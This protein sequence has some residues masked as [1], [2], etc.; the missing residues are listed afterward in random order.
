MVKL[1]TL[2]STLYLSASRKDHCGIIGMSDSCVFT[3]TLEKKVKFWDMPL[4]VF[5]VKAKRG[6]V[7]GLGRGRLREMFRKDNVCKWETKITWVRQKLL[8]GFNRKGRAYSFCLLQWVCLSLP[9][10]RWGL[11]WDGHT[12]GLA[13][14]LLVVAHKE[15]THSFWAV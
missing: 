3:F 8:L 6:N 15:V 11:C 9:R 4:A 2:L 10:K 13:N 1:M 7:A 14:T 5:W 12:H